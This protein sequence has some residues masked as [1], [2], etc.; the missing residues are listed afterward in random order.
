MGE[1]AP[2]F[3][4]DRLGCIVSALSCSGVGGGL[5]ICSRSHWRAPGDGSEWAGEELCSGL[6]FRGA[7][8]YSSDGEAVPDREHSGSSLGVKGGWWL[9]ADL[10]GCRKLGAA[11]MCSSYGPFPPLSLSAL[12]PHSSW[13]HSHPSEGIRVLL[14]Q[15]TRQSDEV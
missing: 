12:G 14:S 15:D 13:K 11:H 5:W 9:K 6:G 1:P 4:Q 3:L 2:H 8:R 10:T 7:S